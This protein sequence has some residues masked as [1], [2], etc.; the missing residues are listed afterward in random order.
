MLFLILMDTHKI[1][2][3]TIKP[4]IYSRMI[5]YEFL[6]NKEIN[7]IKMILYINKYELTRFLLLAKL[8]YA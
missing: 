7:D 1:L 5:Y 3:K 2:N 6:D 4:K 8:L